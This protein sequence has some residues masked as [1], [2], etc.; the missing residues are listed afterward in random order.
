M[1]IL[2]W[3]GEIFGTVVFPNADVKIYL[4]CSLE[5]RAKRR[6][7]Q[8]LEKGI[9]ETYEEVL[10]S[11]IERHKLETEREVAPFI[12]ADDA[13]TIDSTNKSVGE[14][15]YM[16]EHIIARRMKND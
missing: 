16:I 1:E 5:E 14:V 12:K 6:Y 8:N 13:I 15:V 9:N 3:R 2:L 11:M 4:D 7:N 10:K